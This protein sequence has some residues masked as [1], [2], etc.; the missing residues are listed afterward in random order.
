MLG[1]RLRHFVVFDIALYIGGAPLLLD[2]LSHRIAGRMSST[3][4]CLVYSFGL[5]RRL[6]V[7]RLARCYIVLLSHSGRMSLTLRRVV[8]NFTHL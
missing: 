3:L 2:S 6:A 8:Y 1:E 7:A 4:R 5:L